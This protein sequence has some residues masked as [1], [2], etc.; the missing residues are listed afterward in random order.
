MKKRLLILIMLGMS[1]LAGASFSEGQDC[2]M[3]VYTDRPFYSPSERVYI[4]GMVS[5]S[6]ENAVN[7]DVAVE[8][9]APNRNKVFVDQIRTGMGGQ[10]S[11]SFV[12]PESM[13]FGTY[14]IAA[15]NRDTSTTKTFEFGSSPDTIVLNADET[16][17]IKGETVHISGMLIKE[18]AP[19]REEQAA[20][21]VK[22][23]AGNIIYVAQVTTDSHGEFSEAFRITPPMQTGK[24]RVYAAHED[25]VSESVLYVYPNVIINE[26]MFYPPGD[27][28][29][30]EFIELYNPYDEDADMSGW[31]IKSSTGAVA[32]LGSGDSL[33][34][35]GSFAVVTADGTTV[36]VPDGALHFPAGADILGGLSNTGGTIT[37][38]DYNDN[39][40]DSFTYRSTYGSDRDA[41]SVVDSVGEGSS[42][43]RVDPYVLTNY[44]ANWD[45]SIGAPTPSAHNSVYVGYT[46]ANISL[47][48]ADMPRYVMAQRSIEV[49]ARVK[50]SA[51]MYDLVKVTCASDG[52]ELG[53]GPVLIDPL[54]S[55]ERTLLFM[56]N[57]GDLFVNVTAESTGDLSVGDDAKSG[58]I[59]V[60]APVMNG[61]E[62][63]ELFRA[64][65]LIPAVVP[66]GSAFQVIS[67]LAN[68]YDDPVTG[69]SVTLAL[70]QAGGFSAS[71]PLTKAVPVMG[72][73]SVDVSAV[74][75]VEALADTPDELLGRRTFSLYSEG[76]VLGE[77]TWDA[78]F[79]ALEI[80]SHSSPVLSLD[81][82]VMKEADAGERVH[83]VGAA[84]NTGTEP[85]RN[86][87]LTIEAEGLEVL[88]EKAVVINELLPSSFELY[89]FDVM[90]HDGGEHEIVLEIRDQEENSYTL[91]E[92]LHVK[93]APEEASGSG[94]GTGSGTSYSGSSTEP[95][96]VTQK[97]V[98]DAESQDDDVEAP[99]EV[100]DEDEDLYS[101]ED[102]EDADSG[103]GEWQGKQAE[104]KAPTGKVLWYHVV[105]RIVV[106]VL[107]VLLVV[108]L[109]LKPKEILRE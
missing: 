8:V 100:A 13:A 17:Y 85:A 88:S 51:L 84:F 4:Y 20:M 5:D 90:A 75:E 89:S 76:D 10:F 9:I 93:A 50:N 16:R 3:S 79:G 35:G 78:S 86:I 67:V 33:L 103:S 99:D 52:M 24:Y 56:S 61:P 18:G 63:V 49:N 45:S 38:F 105:S 55:G 81:L 71:G 59:T 12:M 46:G 39:M 58:I 11:T 29:G 106:A 97:A 37:L 66:R 60:F 23:K 65:M 77:G 54:S 40:I 69:I 107:A 82:T 44:Y 102:D 2:L 36:A 70:P 14:T 34:A 47:L 25:L 48:F 72:G 41:S 92:T 26:V 30:E 101:F 22:D 62:I 15:S 31:Y 68:E 43:E 108:A 109:V 96:H 21:I 32:V 91:R 7:A 19:A 42:L 98:P 73:N 104:K 64:Q 53:F 6:C 28:A 95:R 27:G 87:I 74:Y 83:L 1:L 94:E 57:A 80:I